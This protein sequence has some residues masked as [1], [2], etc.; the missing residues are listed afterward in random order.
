MC[1]GPDVDSSELSQGLMYIFSTPAYK[2]V[3][4]TGDR[5]FRLKPIAITEGDF[6][7][8]T[9]MDASAEK[10]AVLKIRSAES[11]RFQPKVSR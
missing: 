4:N 11:F 10:S 5:D 2:C 3:V 1:W 6:V 9:I 8:A 7:T